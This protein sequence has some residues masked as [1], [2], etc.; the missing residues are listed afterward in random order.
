MVNLVNVFVEKWSVKGAMCGVEDDI[1]K[2][3][4]DQQLQEDGGDG[5]DLRRLELESNRNHFGIHTCSKVSHNQIIEHDVSCESFEDVAD[6]ML[7]LLLLDSILLQ[8]QDGYVVEIR[9]E[10]R[11]VDGKD[12]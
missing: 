6:P 9:D 11:C 5:R 12:K 2:K 3:R 8:R 10:K 4:K 1:V 7:L